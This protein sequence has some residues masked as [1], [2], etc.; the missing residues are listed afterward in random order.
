MSSGWTAV[1]NG[2]AL[3]GADDAPSGIDASAV[4]GCLTNVPDGL[5]VPGIRTED[6]TMLQR[7]GVMHFSDWYEPRI[8]TLTDVSVCGD[9]CPQCP[10]HRQKV[11]D[12]EQAW[13]RHCGEGEMVLFTDC[14]DPDS[15]VTGTSRAII[16]PYGVVGRPRIATHTWMSGGIKC[17][18][19]LLR[20]DSVDHRL[21]VL[22][23][24]GEPGSGA[25]CVTIEPAISS[26]CRTYPRCYPMCYTV[27]TS[28]PGTGP[29]DVD[30]YGT[31]CAPFTI[32]LTGSLTSPTI[33][34]DTTGQ[35]LTYDTVIPDGGTVTINTETGTAVDQDGIDR[36]EF[37]IGSTTMYA[38]V[39]VNTLR[40][41]SLG[42]SDTGAADICFRPAV[43]SG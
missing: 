39:G 9:G 28:T 22:D 20:F 12:I 25:V 24:S 17:A 43:L 34:N 6:V 30:N 31:L 15:A 11:S 42:A 37:L 36:T 8:I 38:D 2:V 29:Q 19:M 26:R 5:G 7:D 21:Y 23:P 4:K 27:D 1:L 14:H 18:T 10:T 41:T 40:M 3:T 35:S 32:T 13:S 33:S 16:G